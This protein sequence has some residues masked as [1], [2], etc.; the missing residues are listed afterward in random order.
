M[1]FQG[2]MLRG[3]AWA[4]L[5]IAPGGTAAYNRNPTREKR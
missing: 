3:E 2:K 5:S 4:Y 1:T